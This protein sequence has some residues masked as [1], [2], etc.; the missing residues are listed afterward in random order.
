MTKGNLSTLLAQEF[1]ISRKNAYQ[2]IF[3]ELQ[4]CLIPNQFVE[5]AG[6]VF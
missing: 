1:N 6:N 2:Y 4:K 5:E 3:K